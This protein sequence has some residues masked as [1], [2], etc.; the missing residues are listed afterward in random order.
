MAAPRSSCSMN[1][2]FSSSSEY[3][4]YLAIALVICA[5]MAFHRRPLALLPIPLLGWALLMDG[6]RG[7]VLLVV[8]AL[9]VMTGLRMRRALWRLG[10]IAAGFVGVLV[11]AQLLTPLL[12]QTALQTT[13]PLIAHQVGGLLHPFDP[14]RSTFG[15]KLNGLLGGIQFGIQ[16]PAGIGIGATTRPDKFGAAPFATESDVSNAFV[17]LGVGGGILFLVV[18]LGAFRKVNALYAA[19]RD[20]AALAVIGLLLVTLGQWLN[21]GQYAVAPL[22]WFLLGWASREAD[23]ISAPAMDHASPPAP[24]APALQLSAAG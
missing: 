24:A 22:V 6:S 9:I 8:F 16:N 15:F 2:T 13:D 21:G 10:V 23:R 18:I 5:A 3:A 1:G 19:S 17:S 20:W 7:I 14:G 4:T 11:A 12:D